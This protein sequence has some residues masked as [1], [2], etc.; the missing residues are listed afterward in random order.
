MIRIV[1]CDDDPKILDA[2]SQ[3]IMHYAKE[4]NRSDLKIV[5]F[6]SASSLQFALDD[7]SSFD[8]FIL[9]VYIGNEMGT[10]L[11]KSIRKRGIESPIIFLTVSLEHAPEGYET[12]ALRYLLKPV[13]PQKLYEAMDA[14][15]AQAK[16]I[17]ERF[18]GIKTA[19]G[20]ERINVNHIM[21]SEAHAHYQ[22]IMLE[23][24]RQLRSRITVS[25]LYSMIAEYGGFIRVGSAYIINLR[26]IK[27]LSTTELH[28][29]NNITIPIPPP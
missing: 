6:N 2:T 28:L 10:A 14:A 5:T 11:A 19:D 18:I 29:Y 25:D 20:I 17:G 22:Y 1:L 27:N 4:N 23:N 7:D 16:K 26:N 21:F 24:G 13:N 9:D 3:C 8:I 15:L 12:D